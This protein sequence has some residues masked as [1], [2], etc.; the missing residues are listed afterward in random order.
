MHEL[1]AA[2]DLRSNLLNRPIGVLE[3]N[4]LHLLCAEGGELVVLLRSGRVDHA[5]MLPLVVLEIGQLRKGT[6]AVL[7]GIRL[8]S[9]VGGSDMNIQA[10]LLRELLATVLALIVREMRVA[11]IDN[12]ALFGRWNLLRAARHSTTPEGAVVDD[13]EWERG[14]G[15]RHF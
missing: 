12:Q 6:L 11:V 13:G 5:M 2:H 14:G 10:I 9:S 7:A 3:V 8:L 4:P 15:D 1:P